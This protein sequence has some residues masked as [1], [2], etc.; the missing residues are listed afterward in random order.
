M[1]HTVINIIARLLK[2]EGTQKIEVERLSY[3]IINYMVAFGDFGR[4][5]C[6]N[7]SLVEI[8]STSNLVRTPFRIVFLMSNN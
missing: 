3:N 2:G 8:C 4:Q 7:L 6:P 5:N 1:I